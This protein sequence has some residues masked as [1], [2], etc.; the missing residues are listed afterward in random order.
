MTTDIDS[1][2]SELD[3]HVIGL[4]LGVRDYEKHGEIL[5]R[6]FF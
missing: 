6:A 3:E 4:G 5:R 2:A 1:L